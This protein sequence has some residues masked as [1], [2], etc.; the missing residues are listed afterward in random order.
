MKPNTAVL[1]LILLLL[2]ACTVK[3]QTV[4]ETGETQSAIDK[5][6]ASF[7][8]TWANKT[9]NSAIRVRI[10]ETSTHLDTAGRPT[11]RTTRTC[12]IERQDTTHS[13]QESHH[14]S[15]SSVQTVER[16]E[17]RTESKTRKRPA[18]AAIALWIVAGVAL[19]GT[20]YYLFRKIKR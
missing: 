7:T 5:A 20:A 18:S 17:I 15:A 6:S 14:L 10:Y 1:F 2:P 12:V 3:K 9:G 16:E 8:N 19:A 13:Q 4:R 11:R